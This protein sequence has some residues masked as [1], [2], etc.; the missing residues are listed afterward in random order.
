[1]IRN[2][3]P[4]SYASLDVLTNKAL[5]TG[6]EALNTGTEI[7]NSPEKIKATTGFFKGVIKNLVVGSCGAIGQVCIIVCGLSIMWFIINNKSNLA[8][9]GFTGSIMVYIGTKLI[10]IV[11]K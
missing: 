4:I 8:K 10:E 6:V 11:F 3:I 7:I 5:N 2:I 1:M 9:E